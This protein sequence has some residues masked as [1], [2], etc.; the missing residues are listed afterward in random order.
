M[1]GRAKRQRIRNWSI[2]GFVLVLVMLALSYLLQTTSTNLEQRGISSG[3]GF[4]SEPAGFDI[5]MHLI[6]YDESSTY[7]RALLVSI[8]YFPNTAE[9]GL[10]LGGD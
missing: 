3:F 6:D 1:Q 4:L 7:G 10:S 8:F 2:Q 5:S 9:T